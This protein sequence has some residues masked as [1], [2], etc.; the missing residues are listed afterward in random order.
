MRTNYQPFN[1]YGS[2]RAKYVI[3]AMGSVCDTVKLTIEKLNETNDI[4]G[5]IE[6]H[7][8]RPFSTK[9]LLEVLPSSVEKI[10]VLDRTKEAGSSGEQLYLD[11]VAALKEK[12]IN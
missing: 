7:L 3:V 11:V 6:V 8:Y 5:L 12:N 4:Y 2:K 10:A 9:Y 1:Y